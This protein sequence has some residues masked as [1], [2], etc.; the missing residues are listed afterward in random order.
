MLVASVDD[1]QSEAELAEVKTQVKMIF[2]RL[3]RNSE[4]QASIQS[5]RFTLQ[6]DFPFPPPY[7]FQL[8]LTSHALIATS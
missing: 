1:E 4:P 3:D 8:I 5:G 2:R 7:H 6:Y